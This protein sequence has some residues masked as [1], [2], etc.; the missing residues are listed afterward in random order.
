VIFTEGEGKVNPKDYKYSKE[1]EWFC[2]ESADEGKIGISD[3]AQSH[4]GDIVFIDLPAPGTDVKQWG[5][6]GE[7]ESVKAVSDL[8]TPVSGQVLE[9]NQVAIDDPRLVN[10]D[11]YG[12]GWLIR[13]KLSHPS[14]IDALM[15]GEEYDKFTAQSGSE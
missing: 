7:I 8:F 5:K 10:Q 9:V 6:I 11:P 4:L 2:P 1:H 3:Y 12:N 14:E 15:S 13:L